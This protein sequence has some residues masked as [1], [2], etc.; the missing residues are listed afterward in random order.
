MDKRINYL[1]GLDTET[2][3]AI[4]DGKKLDLTQSLVYDLGWNVCDKQGRIYETRSYVVAEVFCDMK[5]LMKTA[6]YAEKIP[7]YQK[8][9]K[10]GSRILASFWTIRK[11]FLK[12]IAEYGIKNVFAHN[13]RFDVRALN[14]TIRFLSQSR[15]RFFFPYEIEICKANK[16]N[17]PIE[18]KEKRIS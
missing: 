13:A 16:I 14:N 5:D 18:K 7:T 4:E 6:Y 9:I 11:Q 2:C 3:N 8:D 10:N 1:I 15:V 12:D 17:K